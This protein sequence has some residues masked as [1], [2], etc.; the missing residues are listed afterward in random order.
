MS[1][2][3]KETT[4]ARNNAA[5]EPGAEQSSKPSQSPASQLHSDAVSLEV[6]LKVHGSKVTEA[7]RGAS[8]QTEPFE[9]ETSSMIVFPHGGV[10]RMSTSVSAGQMLVLTNLKSRQDAICRVVKVR[11]YS[12]SSSYV[13]V[14]FT[15]RQPGFWGVYFESDAIADATP[16]AKP[17]QV[18]E[19][20]VTGS[21]QAVAGTGAVKNPALDKKESTFI[22]IGSQEDVQ[23]AA[24]STSA[25][26]SSKTKPPLPDSRTFQKP[27]TPDTVPPL[28]STARPQPSPAKTSK[29]QQ[30][31]EDA[32]LA[33]T[34][35]EVSGGSAKPARTSKPA[36][37]FTGE[38]FGSQ[39]DLAKQD[40]QGSE[41]KKS[42]LL[43]AI[44]G[45][46]LLLAAA[47]AG[48][49]W[50]HKPTDSPVAQTQA[51]AAPVMPSPAVQV[52]APQP[53]I[54]PP[55]SKPSP[56]P[57]NS[58]RPTP[59]STVR[60][61]KET[62]TITES[63]AAAAAPESSAPAAPARKPVPSIFG[64]LNSHPVA[65]RQR[66]DGAAAPKV[67][68]VAAPSG[69][70]LAGIATS[71][72]NPTAPPAP[73]LRVTAPIQANSGGAKLP[74]LLVR[75]I[76]QYPPLAK[77]THTEGDVM[78]EIAVDKTGN[79]TDAKVL[80]G[81]AALRIAAIGAVK[82]WKYQ[83]VEG[84]TDSVKMTVTIQ[85]RL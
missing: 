27:G 35:G 5:V 56:A 55:V 25:P 70:A 64:A 80:S 17:A 51:T 75:V 37:A 83:P 81:P 15:H 26:S 21:K 29:T 28:A 82:R 6:P 2:I 9:E 76:P 20:E 77:Q 47:G 46:A 63:P 7:V 65:P 40:E 84:Q 32:S 57:Q 79:V 67:D 52:P 85:F 41:G 60:P 8:P 59:S 16:A 24:S 31:E 18:S 68:A 42:G 23:P 48:I 73:A 14:E 22:A 3:S 4:E 34:L 19:P 66:T 58:L 30:E 45:V 50:H 38:A 49:L 13:E 62:V 12:N 53:A 74:Q 71:S 39:G 43:I 33:E 54:V 72:V 69:D 78:L 11:S 36:R 1:T 44:C 61:P 10:L